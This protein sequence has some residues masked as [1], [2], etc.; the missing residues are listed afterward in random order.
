MRPF[1][2]KCPASGLRCCGK[3]EVAR[4]CCSPIGGG[5]RLAGVVADEPRG[6]AAIPFLVRVQNVKVD[7]LCSLLI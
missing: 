6:L 1:K 2:V 5:A 4:G 7:V 3:R